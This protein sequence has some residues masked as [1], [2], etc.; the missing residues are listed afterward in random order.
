MH[1]EES[2]VPEIEPQVLH[3]LAEAADALMRARHLTG[4]GH[5]EDHCGNALDE[6]K[7]AVRAATGWISDE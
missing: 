5:V 4:H 7:K 3:K 2:A 6:I 1:D